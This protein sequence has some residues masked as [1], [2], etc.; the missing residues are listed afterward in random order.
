MPAALEKEA[1]A[2]E[3]KTAVTIEVQVRVKHGS[4]FTLICGKIPLR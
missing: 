2:K 1:N 3:V 4:I